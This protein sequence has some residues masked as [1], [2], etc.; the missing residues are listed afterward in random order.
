M[1]T[2]EGSDLH[3]YTDIH[4]NIVL[5]RIQLCLYSYGLYSYGLYS[6]GLYG[7]G[8]YSYGLY[9]YCTQEVAQLLSED[10][11]DVPGGVCAV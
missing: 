8:L 10:E 7:Y 9:S 11:G 3:T 4:G 5:R 1:T 6:Y 2:Y